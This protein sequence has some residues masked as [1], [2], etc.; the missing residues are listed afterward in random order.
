MFLFSSFTKWPAVA[1][2][3]QLPS[4]QWKSSFK[5]SIDR[6]ESYP[7]DM[8]SIKAVID[9]NLHLL[10][11]FNYNRQRSILDLRDEQRLRR[12]L[13]HQR[14][15]KVSAVL[16]GAGT[17]LL[18]GEK[19]AINL[20]IVAPGTQQFQRSRF[21]SGFEELWGKK[22]KNQKLRGSRRCSN[23]VNLRSIQSVQ[24]EIKSGLEFSSNELLPHSQSPNIHFP[25]IKCS[26]SD[27]LTQLHGESTL[28]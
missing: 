16:W 23:P 18:Q 1:A 17:S 11:H 3:L 9:S 7:D 13:G 26:Q 15:K 22:I 2:V 28:L 20:H 19:T 14:V 21:L 10:G 6:K 25:I 24:T 5:S 8:W 27:M 4:R 12:S